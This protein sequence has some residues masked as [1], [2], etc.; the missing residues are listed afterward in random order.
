MKISTSI[1]ICAAGTFMFTSCRV[2][3][4]VS[5]KTRDSIVV[6]IKDSTVVHDVTV[7]KDSIVVKDSTIGIAGSS[8]G[9]TI[10]N[11]STIDTTTHEGNVNLHRYVDNKGKEHIDCNSDSL[12]LVIKNLI[13]EKTESSQRY[14][15]M[16]IAKDSVSRSHSEVVVKQ[17]ALSW[18]GRLWTNVEKYF[19]W[20][21]VATLAFLAIK[22]GRK[23]VV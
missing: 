13:R 22:Y 8:T 20:L 11:G 19:A 6:R 12:T 7:T 17:Q 21:G 23:I 10:Q 14:D 18:W 15:S 2:M 4:P 5:V 3:K 9:V 1:L 16:S